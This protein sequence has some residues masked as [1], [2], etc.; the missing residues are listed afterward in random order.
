MKLFNLFKNKD[1]GS[2]W[3]SF[4]ATKK[5]YPKPSYTKITITTKSGNSA[6]GR[7]NSS[8]RWYWYKKFTPYN[9]HFSIW[10]EKAKR[11]EED[12][13]A[14]EEYFLSHLREKCVAHSVCIIATDFGM[15][16]DI[17]LDKLEPAQEVLTVLSDPETKEVDFAVSFNND[18]KW[19]AYKKLREKIYQN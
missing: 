8:Y 6:T 11:R 5:L 9:L 16:L 4:K 10:V 15:L 17:Y 19:A 13:D 1:A 7:L 2:S 3:E 14:M 18:P 12:L